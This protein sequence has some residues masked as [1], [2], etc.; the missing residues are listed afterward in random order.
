LTKVNTYNTINICNTVNGEDIFM[1]RKIISVSLP[2]KL[3]SQLDTICKKLDRGKSWAIQKA[4]QNFLE[5]QAD[6]IVAHARSNDGSQP[7]SADEVYA[8]LGI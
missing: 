1:T 8:E 3:A 4:L 2:D 5:D 7:I 6:G